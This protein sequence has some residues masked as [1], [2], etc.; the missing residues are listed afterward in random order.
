LSTSRTS[1]EIPPELAAAV[2]KAAGPVL[3]GP[4]AT[5]TPGGATLEAP[6][7][8]PAPFGVYVH[9]PF[10][11]RRCDYCAFA[12]WSDRH[13]LWERYVNGLVTQ[14]SSWSSAPGSATASGSATRTAPATAPG[15]ATRTAPATAPGSATRTA[16]ATASGSPTRT[17]PAT[18]PGSATRTAPAAWARGPATSVFFGGGTPS[19][20]PAELLARALEGVRQGPGMAPGAEVTVECNPET[21]SVGKLLAYR[22]AGVTRLSFGA[23]SMAPHVL[24]SLGR[25]HDPASVTRAA[26]MASEAGFE[27]AYNVDLIFGAAGEGRADWRATLEAV[28][29]LSP[30]P[31]HVSAYALTVEPGTPL[32]RDPSR[33]PSDDD[34]ADKYMLAESVLTGAG[35]QWYE[36]SNWARPGAECA[37]NL[38]YWS[39]GEY[40]GIGCAAHSHRAD[41]DGG[42]ARRWWNVRT[43]E[44]FC[45]LV[46]EGAPVEAAGEHLSLEERAW[47][48]LVLAVRTRQ[49]VPP[50]TAPSDLFEAGLM[51]LGPSGGGAARAVLTLR[52]RLLANE[53]ATRLEAA[54]RP[55]PVRH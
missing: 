37:H 54:G 26:R 15:S 10:C 21:L 13:H 44:R 8:T 55:E 36:I 31:S 3:K 6:G 1:E 30:P 35:Y 43:P 50:A 52:G 28:V 27:S 11:R 46:E 45:Q 12:T 4:G 40:A 49:G 18:A 33:H 42:G 29:A 34:Q 47:E 9:V 22:E 23:Q 48:A 39:Q 38:L 17:A 20:L 19:L 25:E 41:D 5:P 32:A 53:V 51:E 16:P 2:A 14:L 24:A 7:A